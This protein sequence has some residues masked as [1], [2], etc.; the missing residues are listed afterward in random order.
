MFYPIILIWI[1]SCP[2]ICY[3]LISE[4]PDLINFIPAQ[5]ILHTYTGSIVIK[6]SSILGKIELGKI[7]I[8]VTYLSKISLEN[9]TV[10]LFLNLKSF[11]GTAKLSGKTVYF[12]S[13]EQLAKAFNLSLDSFSFNSLAAP[14]SSSY[15]FEEYFTTLLSDP[16]FEDL[17]NLTT[18]FYTLQSKIKE[19]LSITQG[20]L[21]RLLNT[22]ED[23]NQITQFAIDKIENSHVYFSGQASKE[24]NFTPL[25]TDYPIHWTRQDR[26]NF[27]CNCQ[28]GFLLEGNFS[29]KNV[30]SNLKNLPKDF[31]WLKGKFLVEIKATLS[32]AIVEEEIFPLSTAPQEIDSI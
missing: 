20:E 26:F 7:K 27:S 10:T 4:L 9:E 3:N 16:A 32:S 5:P 13:Y 25:L 18:L 22:S 1:L 2:L 30:F 15:L 12:E 31:F 19:S 8:L 6:R 28:N 23:K 24:Y 11:S 17:S 29:S 14:S 21:L